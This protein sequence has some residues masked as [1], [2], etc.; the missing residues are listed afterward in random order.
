MSEPEE[1]VGAGKDRRLIV[2]LAAAAVLALI[3]C[4]ALIVGGISFVRGRIP[5]P[6]SIPEAITLCDL[7]AS[8]LCLVSFGTNRNNELVIN[9][10]LAEADL[11]PFYAQVTSRGAVRR[12]TCEKMAAV[13]NEDTGETAPASASCTG[14]RTPLGEPLELRLYAL[15]DDRLL[16]EGGFVLQAVALPTFTDATATETLEGTPG[17]PETGTLTPT[18]GGGGPPFPSRTPGLPV[19]TRTPTPPSGYP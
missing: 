15:S 8:G 18:P 19:G 4:A 1:R 9:L 2:I 6:T 11:P 17:T 14:P 3:V 13:E 7:D 5:T 10:Q 12:F 16:A